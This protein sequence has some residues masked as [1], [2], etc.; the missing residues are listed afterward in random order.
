MRTGILAIDHRLDHWLSIADEIRLMA[1]DGT[2]DG[3]AYAPSALSL[4]RGRSGASAS[5]AAPTRPPG[6]SR[7]GRRRWC[8]PCGACGSP[9]MGARCCGT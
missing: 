2:L 3:A 6:R 4:R 9:R 7:P 8:S 1:Q 5:P